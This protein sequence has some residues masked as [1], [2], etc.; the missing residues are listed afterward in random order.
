M[1]ISSSGLR[2]HRWFEAKR[3]LVFCSFRFVHD[4][5]VLKVSTELPC[6]RFDIVSFGQNKEHFSRG[7][8]FPVC[9]PSSKS[10]KSVGAVI[11][12]IF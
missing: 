3:I 9:L 12:Q 11:I 2:V 10:V 5:A 1:S 7:Q 4:I 8:L 6:S